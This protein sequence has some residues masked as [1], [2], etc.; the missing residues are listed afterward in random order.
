MGGRFTAGLPRGATTGDALVMADPERVGRDAS[1]RPQSS[2]ARAPRPLRSAG[3]AVTMLE[4]RSTDVS[5][6]RSSTRT[7]AASCSN[8]I[9]RVS[10]WRTASASLTAHLPVYPA[11]LRRR[12]ICR[13]KG[14]AATS[15]AVEIVRK[16][17]DQVGFAVNRGAGSSSGSSRGSGE[18][19]DW[20]KTSRPPSTPH[21]PSSTPHPSCC[22]CDGS[23]VLHD[24]RNRL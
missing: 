9:R 10:W 16:N 17:P 23:L 8:R 14:T 21:A 3:H 20:Q 4:R 5:A 12:R 19:G 24:F 6:M 15:I 1:P 22:S 18:I 7:G 2:T 13:G 11:R